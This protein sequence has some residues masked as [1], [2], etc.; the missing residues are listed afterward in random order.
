MFSLT[1]VVSPAQ[2]NWGTGIHILRH[3]D[4]VFLKTNRYRIPFRG[5]WFFAHND[6]YVSR[7]VA[8]DNPFG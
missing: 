8:P 6:Q 5:K 3:I 4:S 1:P 2:K 7:K